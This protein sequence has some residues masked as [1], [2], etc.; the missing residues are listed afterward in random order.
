MPDYYK[1]L[2]ERV[3]AY[4]EGI[5]GGA[6]L[7]IVK[8][9]EGLADFDVVPTFGAG[10]MLVTMRQ[11]RGRQ[12]L[13]PV[14]GTPATSGD[15]APPPQSEDVTETPAAPTPRYASRTPAAEDVIPVAVLNL[16]QLAYLGEKY[17]VFG[18][19]QYAKDWFRAVNWDRVQHRAS[20]NIF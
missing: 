7:W 18:A 8:S 16:Y 12:G 13:I 9:G 6:W 10:T 11:Q 19:R 4:A 2:E 3:A 20:A 15:A 5:T 14:F 17:G 1:P